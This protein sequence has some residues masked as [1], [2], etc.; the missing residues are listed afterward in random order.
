MNTS[1]RTARLTGA[2]YLGLAVFGM[3]GFLLVRPQLHDPS[4]PLATLGTLQEHP[5]LTA[6]A[7]ALELT[8][9]LAQA[10][11][12][13]GFFALMR[14]DQPTAGFGV[15]VFGM[16]NAV[17]ILASAAMLAGA[18]AVASDP[19]L[20]PGADAAGTVA[21]LF[22]LSSSL[23]NVG[24]IFFGLWLI[25]MGAFILFTKRMP[26]P[27]G[28]VLAIGGV[29]YVASAFVS[30]T[31]IDLGAWGDL[32]TIPATIGELWIV[33]YLLVWGI[34]PRLATSSASASPRNPIRS[35]RSRVRTDR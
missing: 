32:L 6:T 28:W 2:A 31:G 27:L 14:S 20:A 18:S 5:A 21:L 29:G 16:A 23:W 7:I 11:A 12:A 10:L 33:I 4:D 22:A 26:R 17:T 8:I 1:T 25:P 34:R 19:S 35:A 13:L 24:A 30:S 9:V 3:L 15:A